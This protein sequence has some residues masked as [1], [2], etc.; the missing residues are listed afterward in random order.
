MVVGGRCPTRFAQLCPCCGRE[1]LKRE[2]AWM[3][4]YGFADWESSCGEMWTRLH[5]PPLLWVGH[6][7]RLKYWL[8]A[9]LFPCACAAW[10]RARCVAMPLPRADVAPCA[11]ESER[12]RAMSRCLMDVAM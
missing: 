6:Q 4:D 7:P 1:V 2:A 11:A 10:L 12:S 5:V 8:Q 9:S 3:C